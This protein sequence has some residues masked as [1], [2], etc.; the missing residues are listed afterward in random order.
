[1]DAILD[2]SEAL[3]Q[4]S[5]DGD[6]RAIS[7]QMR[8]GRFSPATSWLTDYPLD[9]IE[10]VLRVKGPA[11]LCDEIK[12]DENPLYVEHTLKWAILS[13]VGTEGFHGKRILDFG[14][15]TRRRFLGDAVE[16][17]GP[18]RHTAGDSGFAQQERKRRQLAARVTPGRAGRNR[19]LVQRLQNPQR[20][21]CEKGSEEH[22]QGHKIP[23]RCDRNASPDHRIGVKR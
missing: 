14:S 17:R 15:G 10:H 13:Y 7:V 1:M 9:L 21:R 3:V 2:N 11:Y 8:D 12:R 23:D 20:L 19:R 6:K 18:G 22:F 4:V 5:P 16:K